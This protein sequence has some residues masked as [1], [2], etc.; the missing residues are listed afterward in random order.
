VSPVVSAHIAEEQAKLT[1][2]TTTPE[3][4]HGYGR[5]LSCVSDISPTLDEVDG[6]DLLAI[7]Q[8][9]V[10]RLT[11]PRGSLPDDPDYGIDIRSYLNVGITAAGITQ[12]ES[13]IA[14]ELAK[15]DRL[16]AVSTTFTLSN[17]TITLRVLA[18]P[19]DSSQ[20][21]AFTITVDE[22][23]AQLELLAA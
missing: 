17:K 18:T 11:T 4:P 6:F 3:P 20:E 10:R 9:A 5:D 12:A 14:N 23:S 21:F 13:E 22:F 19:I 15:D 2:V 1:R 7:A 8:A 16:D